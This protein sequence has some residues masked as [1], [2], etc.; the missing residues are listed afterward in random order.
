MTRRSVIVK[1][2]ED[3]GGWQLIWGDNWK[4]ADERRFATMEAAGRV[5]RA[6][7]GAPDP[8]PDLRLL[9]PSEP[10]RALASFPPLETPCPTTAMR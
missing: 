5:A 10:P 3:G 8:Q 1:H 9:K 2:I 6:L 4:P 7:M